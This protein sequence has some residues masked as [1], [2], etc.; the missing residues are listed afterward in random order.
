MVAGVKFLLSN[1][2]AFL[3]VMRS[4]LS[5]PISSFPGIL[6]ASCGVYVIAAL[7]ALS[8]ELSVELNG[9]RKKVKLLMT[10]KNAKVLLRRNLPPATTR[11]QGKRRT[12]KMGISKFI[13]NL[14]ST[15]KMFALL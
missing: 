13:S 12:F 1:T 9:F 15:A 6:V 4:F 7:D 8:D 3:A 2:L 14:H 11:N 10:A 5:A